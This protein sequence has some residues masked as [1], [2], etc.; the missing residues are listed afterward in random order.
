M[1]RATGFRRLVH[2]AGIVIGIMVFSATAGEAW[3][4][5]RDGSPPPGNQFL[6]LSKQSRAGHWTLATAADF[7]TGQLLA[8]TIRESPD[9]VA[10]EGGARIGAYLSAPRRTDFPFNGVAAMWRAS[11]PLGGNLALE[12]RTGDDGATW[13]NWTRMNVVDQFAG[14]DVE[15]SDL[16]LARGSYLQFRVI[17]AR[18]EG[19]PSPELYEVALAY[20]DTAV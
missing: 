3:H 5:R 7:R 11:H 4:E 10:L 13:S 1:K 20:L 16:I 8:V 6:T 19:G 15:V 17:M 14:Y 18:N 2:L 9:A 12:L